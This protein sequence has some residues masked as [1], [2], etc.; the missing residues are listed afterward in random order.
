MKKT[1]LF[2]I[3]TTCCYY[4]LYAQ[5]NS[6]P[7]I[8]KT[9]FIQSRDCLIEGSLLSSSN[10]STKQKLAIIIA[11]SGPTD[12]NGN[13]AA[14]V[15]SNSY[16]MLAEELAKQDI[17]TYRYD[18]R[19][20][21]KSAYKEFKEKDLVFDDYVNDATTI[22]DYLEDTLGFRDIYFIGHSEGSL[23]GMIASRQKQVKGYIS[24]SGAGR[25]I[26]IIIDEQIKN[27]PPFVKNKIDSIFSILKNNKMVDSVP[28]Y[29]Y[30]LFRPSVQPYMISWLKY[31]P[32][33]E[34]KKLEVPILILQGE[35]DVQVKA[36]DAENLHNANNKSIIDII[37]GMTHTLKNAGGNC[38]DDNNKTYTDSSLPLNTQ[39]VTDI[40]SFIKEKK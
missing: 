37:P 10:H 28:P 19:G 29:L 2:F 13:S 3:I 18:K 27:Q 40:A 39:L 14:G 20:I 6:K 23:I 21:G 16:K 17:S 25:P 11:G 34:I 15:S 32:A 36:E 22:F 31:N 5:D 8:E 9:V 12:R 30:R 7:F 38:K 33:D 4:N 24:L 35:C 26:D 1:T